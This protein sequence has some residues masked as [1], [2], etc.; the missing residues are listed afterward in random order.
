MTRLVALLSALLLSGCLG[1]SAP[2]SR[3]FSPLAELPEAKPAGDTLLRFRGLKAP[4]HLKDKIV[5]R[6]SDVEVGV[7]DLRRWLAEPP[8]MVADH[9]SR[10]L[11]Q[12][13]GLRRTLSG[14]MPTLEVTLELFEEELAPGHLVRIQLS[15]LLVDRAQL[16]LLEKTYRVEQPIASEE[17]EDMA[18]AMDKALQSL[19]GQVADDVVAALQ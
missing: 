14:S 15:A 9:L 8:E 6:L 17:P 3:Y 2:H 7:Y 11:Y 13:R 16:S 1:S 18:R 12:A 19:T 5:W 4:P 10:E